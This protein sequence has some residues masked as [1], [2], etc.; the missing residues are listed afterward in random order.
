MKRTILLIDFLAIIAFSSASNLMK[1]AEAFAEFQ[2]FPTEGFAKFQAEIENKSLG[3][4]LTSHLRQLRD[5]MTKIQKRNSIYAEESKQVYENIMDPY[6]VEG[7]NNKSAPKM[8]AAIVIE[9]SRFKAISY[10][11]SG[12]KHWLEDRINIMEE[13]ADKQTFEK[14]LEEV[15]AAR[16]DLHKNS[17]K[18]LEG[19]EGMDSILSGKR[20][21]TRNQSDPHEQEM[22]NAIGKVR[23]AVNNRNYIK[24]TD[25]LVKKLN[26]M[27]PGITVESVKQSITNIFN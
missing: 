11:L 10:G 27:A 9:K 8:A 7:Y 14:L 21:Q 22:S 20:P 26:D 18:F 24:L 2:K 5:F 13:G 1:N 19:I 4:H 23:Q 6:R 17:E 3:K 25:N 16:N 12:A 15:T